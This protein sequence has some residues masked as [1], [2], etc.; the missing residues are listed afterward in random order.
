VGKP[1]PESARKTS[2]AG[3]GD[4]TSMLAR[5][6]WNVESCGLLGLATVGPEP[7]QVNER[8]RVS[9]GFRHR[10]PAAWFIAFSSFFFSRTLFEPPTI[11]KIG[12][13][14]DYPW[15]WIRSGQQNTHRWIARP[16]GV[17]DLTA[18]CTHLGAARR[19]GKPAKTRSSVRAMERLR[20]VKASFRK[21]PAP[22]PMDPRARGIRSD[23]QIIVDNLTLYQWP[24]DQRAILTIQVR[25]LP[26]S[27]AS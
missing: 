4:A 8:R 25:F 11:F 3:G 10:I 21:G 13:P 26:Y 2:T 6:P 18:A 15:V 7:S 1:K 23:G 19:L 20:T 22:R 9:C 17:F 5:L 12:Y 14:S 16:I 27:R 24:R